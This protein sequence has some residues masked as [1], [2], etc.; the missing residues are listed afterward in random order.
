ML[1]KSCNL[2]TQEAL[3]ALQWLWRALYKYEYKKI[4]YHRKITVASPPPPSRERDELT[5]HLYI[6]LRLIIMALLII[7]YN[8]Y[9]YCN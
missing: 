8:D 5:N 2:T 4:Q 7:N 3:Q 6:T 1:Y 9:T